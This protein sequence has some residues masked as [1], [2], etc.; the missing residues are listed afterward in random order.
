M[1]TPLVRASAPGKLF[2]FGEYG[3]LAAGTC[4]VAAVGRRVFAERRSDPTGYE[5]LGASLDDATALPEAVL[6]ELPDARRHGCTLGQLSTDIRQ[7]YTDPT[8]SEDCAKLGLGSSAASVVALCAACL[9]DESAPDSGPRPKG[10]WHIGIEIRGELF[11]RAFAAHRRLQGGRGSGA[12]VAASSFGGAIG[13]RLQRPAAGFEGLVEPQDFGDHGRSSS[14]A[15]VRPGLSFPE[16]LRIE[17][18][19]LGRPA[20]STSFV[21]L[22]EQALREAPGPTADA[23]RRTSEIAQDALDA[24]AGGDSSRLVALVERGDRALDELGA[25]IEA[26]IV[27]PSHRQLREAAMGTGI[28]V[29]PSGAGGG[30]FSLAFGP[31]D[32]AW[33]RFL[34]RLPQK[35]RH[36]PLE[37]GVD[38]VRLE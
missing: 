31:H 37:F 35:C 21:R 20:R 22:C 28:N 6:A 9:L 4:V 11:E 1:S 13:Y 36:I 26:P 34:G 23:L 10:E 15:A 32:A 8:S 7:L 12:D 17:P 25:V 19:W 24:L 18:I 3:V 30:D 38:G 14:V 27:T 5:A 29:K 33:S 16:G 2:L